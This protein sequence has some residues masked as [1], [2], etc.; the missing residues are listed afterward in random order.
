MRDRAKVVLRDVVGETKLD[1]L[2]VAPRG[3][4]RQG[5]RRGRAVRRAVGPA[6]RA[7]RAPGHPAPA[8]DAGGH[9]AEGDRR[10]RPAVRRSSR[11]RPTSRARRTSPRPRASSTRRPAR[12]EL[13]RLEALQNLSGGTTKVIFDLAK[14]FGDSQA[15]AVAAAMGANV[16]VADDKP[17]EAETVGERTVDEAPASDAMAGRLRD[18]RSARDGVMS[19]RASSTIRCASGRSRRSARSATRSRARRSSRGRSRS[20]T[21]SSRGRARTARCTRIASSSSFPRTLHAQR[22][23]EPRGEGR[24]RGFAR[25]RDGRARR[26]RGRR[27]AHRGRRATSFG[28]RAVPQSVVT[29]VT[30]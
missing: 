21:T 4:R 2:L 6:R 11:A 28:A 7:H 18:P 25:S 3:G 15:A 13:R 16:R 14:P 1:D 19:T 27:R 5:P 29:L 9:R 30:T 17:A 23:G 8:A 10:A 22:R 20:S 26:P 12:M 24:P